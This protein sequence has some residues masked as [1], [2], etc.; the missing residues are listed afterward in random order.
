MNTSI[1][2]LKLG[3]RVRYRGLTVDRAAEPGSVGTITNV[4]YRADHAWWKVRWD[5]GTESSYWAAELER[6][7]SAS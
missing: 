6:L 7:G 1:V 2:E 5:R 4:S 3:D